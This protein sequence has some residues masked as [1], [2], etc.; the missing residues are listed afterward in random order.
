MN[1]HKNAILHS[2]SGFMVRTCDYNTITRV[3]YYLAR[4]IF[5]NDLE[6]N[7]MN[8]GNELINNIILRVQ[9]VLLVLQSNL[10][11]TRKQLKLLKYY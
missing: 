9:S 7:A 6:F 1:N 11:F 2:G 10:I 4:L 3:L 8:K 5:V